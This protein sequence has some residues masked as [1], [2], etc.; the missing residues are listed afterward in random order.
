VYAYESDR[1]FEVHVAYRQAKIVYDKS[2]PQITDWADGEW[3]KIHFEQMR[4]LE[5][6]EMIPVEGEYAGK[7]FLFHTVGEFY[8]GMK[9]IQEKG[10]H[11]PGWVFDD[12]REEMEKE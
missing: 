1:G 11:V 2:F 3:Y 12:I 7:D 10:H 4:L 5:D 8:E 9:D 6:T